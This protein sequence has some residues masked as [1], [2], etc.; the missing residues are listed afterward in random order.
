MFVCL[1]TRIPH[2]APFSLCCAVIGSKHVKVTIFCQSYFNLIYFLVQ[3]VPKRQTKRKISLHVEAAV[4]STC[5]G[6]LAVMTISSDF[7]VIIQILSTHTCSTVLSNRSCIDTLV[8]D[9]H[10]VVDV[11]YIYGHINWAFHN[12]SLCQCLH[13]DIHSHRN[14]GTD[15]VR[16][17]LATTLHKY[18][19]VCLQ[20]E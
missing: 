9:R 17:F 13:L 8:K 2:S 7:F 1:N 15:T 11:Q 18:S 4:V 12:F 19:F 3:K 6:L 16:T 14:T 10:V 20:G 5:D